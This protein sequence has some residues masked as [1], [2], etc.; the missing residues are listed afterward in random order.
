MPGSVANTPVCDAMSCMTSSN[1]QVDT[2]VRTIPGTEGKNVSTFQGTHEYVEHS[3]S[4]FRRASN[5]SGVAATNF[6]GASGAADSEDPVGKLTY[7]VAALEVGHVALNA[8]SSEL[9]AQHAKLEADLASSSANNAELAAQNAKL[10]AGLE[11]SNAQ[12]VKLQAGLNASNATSA[13]LVVRTAELKASAEA[14]SATSAELNARN[15]KLEAGLE[16]SN[17]TSAELVAQNE[18]LKASVEASIATSAEFVAQTTELKADLEASMA[19]SDDLVAQ[20]SE[21]V[22][23]NTRLAKQNTTLAKLESEVS[24]SETVQANICG[25]ELISL[26]KPALK[27]VNSRGRQQHISRQKVSRIARTHFGPRRHPIHHPATNTLAADEQ[28]EETAGP[29]CARV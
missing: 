21:L 3:A 7:K 23:Q 26:H 14:S 24:I 4:S 18:K 27:N 15:A 28:P 1:D 11:A 13:E 20:N 6:A 5:P 25:W 10:E 17:A 22:A 12:N 9:A 19:R 8:T 2:L 16:A 29:A